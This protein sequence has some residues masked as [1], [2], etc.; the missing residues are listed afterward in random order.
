VA[1][2][3]VV[4]VVKTKRQAPYSSYV[5]VVAKPVAETITVEFG[6][7]DEDVPCTWVT[8]QD[9]IFV[10][11]EQA[12]ADGHAYAVKSDTC[13]VLIRDGRIVKADIFDRYVIASKDPNTFTQDKFAGGIELRLFSYPTDQQA[14]GLP[15]SEGCVA[16]V[17]TRLH[18]DG[19]PILD[20]ISCVERIRIGVKL[21]WADQESGGVRSF[22]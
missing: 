10:V 2:P 15:D 14:I 18:V 21:V 4:A 11:S 1:D 19:V 9:T 5:K 17:G 6:I 22:Q 3:G 13:A 8:R 12:V 7:F 20:N 16:R